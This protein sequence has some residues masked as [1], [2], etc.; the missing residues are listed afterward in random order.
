MFLVELDC[1]LVKFNDSSVPGEK[2]KRMKGRKKGTQ[3]Y[4]VT[5]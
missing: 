3:M 2:K 5:N 1:I 4:N